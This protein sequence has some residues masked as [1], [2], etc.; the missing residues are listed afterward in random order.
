MN[1]TKRSNSVGGNKKLT[2]KTHYSGFGWFLYLLGMSA[3]PTKVDFINPETGE[4]VDS[5]TDPE[6][7]KKYVGR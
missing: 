4:I 3:K 2:F 5:T 1:Q 7:L 6:E